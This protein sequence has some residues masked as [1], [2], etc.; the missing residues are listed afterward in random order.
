MN[1]YDIVLFP[2]TFSQD[3]IKSENDELWEAQHEE[4]L[5]KTITIHDFFRTVTYLWFCI[6][7]YYVFKST[8]TRIVSNTVQY[9]QELCKIRYCDVFLYV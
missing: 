2:L 1:R 6:T 9:S 8:F 5:L 3:L 4:I 7:H